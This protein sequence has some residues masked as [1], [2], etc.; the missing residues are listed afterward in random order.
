MAPL[1][2]DASRDSA[3][4]SGWRVGMNRAEQCLRSDEPETALAVYE[5]M[6]AASGAAKLVGVERSKTLNAMGVL[7]R[8]L[9]RLEEAESALRNAVSFDP[10]A[11]VEHFN[12]GD[13]LDDLGR[14]EA[15]VWSFDRAI[16]LDPNYGAAYMNKGVALD[17]LSRYEDA[18]AAYQTAADLLPTEP[19]IPFNIG[20]SLAQLDRHDEAVASFDVAISKYT[21]K[22]HACDAL[23]DKALSLI[24][25]D[26][27]EEALACLDAAIEASEEDPLPFLHVTKGKLCS[28]TGDH[29]GAVDA[30]TRAV[31][32]D[33]QPTFA[34][35]APAA[36]DPYAHFLLGE[37]Y[38]GLGQ[39][40]DALAEFSEAVAIHD[41]D[42]EALFMKG[43]ALA[44][45]RRFDAA[46]DCI[47][48]ASLVLPETQVED[49]K[50][51]HSD[52]LQDLDDKTSHPSAHRISTWKTD[53]PLRGGS[54]GP[55]LVSSPLSHPASSPNK[56]SHSNTRGSDPPGR[57]SASEKK[58]GTTP[59]LKP[60]KPLKPHRAAGGGAPLTPRSGVIPH[61]ATCSWQYSARGQRHSSPQAGGQSPGHFSP[62]AAGGG[63]QPVAVFRSASHCS[64]GASSFGTAATRTSAACRR[65]AKY[66]NPVLPLPPR[67]P[68][69]KPFAVSEGEDETDEAPPPSQAK[70]PPKPV[71]VTAK[72]NRARSPPVIPEGLKKRKKE[73]DEDSPLLDDESKRMQTDSGMLCCGCA[74]M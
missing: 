25:M 51:K 56:S 52:A 4:Q 57:D 34:A 27:P 59:S 6:L 44:R 23:N 73:S 31:A 35:P 20:V 3:E 68:A 30:L 8:S 50:A 48:D 11:V 63:Q 21:D 19:L 61:S 18:I 36:K 9:G 32:L 37:A 28:A 1:N 72:G 45:L 22:S 24:A 39:L 42:G 2:E 17:N 74:V 16:A 33:E 53:S 14:H 55:V 54:V 10:T 5:E 46:L 7:L 64:A 69:P 26:R 60:L 40:E 12:L 47:E 70:S 38:L 58:T 41:G 62:Q 49:L 66:H 15:A 71:V 67:D 43:V 13:V 29:R 65:K